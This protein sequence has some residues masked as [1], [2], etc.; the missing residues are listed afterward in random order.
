M[1]AV[2][3][4]EIE[5]VRYYKTDSFWS[6]SKKFT[7]AKIHDDGKS[8]KERFFV[9]LCS[10][11]KPFKKDEHPEDEYN[12]WI[13]KYSGSLYGYQTVKS[14]GNSD[15]FSLSEDAQLSDP[16]YLRRIDSISRS[17]IVESSDAIQ[18]LRDEK[19][20]QIIGNKN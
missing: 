6:K 1:R 14:D 16:I 8:D 12:D 19:I 10:G 3:F 13:L 15:R 5:G 7:D 17:G 11:F 20:D 2:Y 4:V 18:I 9:S